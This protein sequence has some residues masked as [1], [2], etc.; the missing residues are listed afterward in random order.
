MPDASLPLAKP[1]LEETSNLEL[2]QRACCCSKKLILLCLL[3]GLALSTVMQ[4]VHVGD[5]QEQA[6]TLA[7]EYIHLAG[8]QQQLL[9][10]RQAWQHMPSWQC[11]HSGRG[12][13]V[14]IGS[15]SPRV[16]QVAQVSGRPR[17]CQ[18]SSLPYESGELSEF[19]TTNAG[20]KMPRLIYTTVSQQESTEDHVQRAVHAGFKGLQTAGQPKQYYE[21]GVGAALKSLFASGISRES[22]FIQTSF[23]PDYAA[24]L[25]PDE[26]IEDQ[27]K[28]SIKDS[29]SNLGL[30]YVDSLLLDLPYENHKQTME[31]WRTMEAAVRAGLVRQLGMSNVETQMQLRVILR[32]AELKPAVVQVSRFNESKR[33]MQAMCAKSGIHIQSFKSLDSDTSLFETMQGFATKYSVTPSA[34]F[35]RFLMG[36]GIVPLTATFSDE[37]MR[38]D[39]SAYR[40]PLTS[41]D[42]VK[43]YEL[44]Q[45][46]NAL[47][48][49]P[50]EVS[51]ANSLGAS[52]QITNLTG[53]G[54]FLSTERC[55]GDRLIVIKFY[56]KWC[57]TCKAM[58]KQ[59]AQLAL[60]FPE[61]RFFEMDYDANR[62]L[63]R[64]LGISILPYVEMYR[65]ADGKLEGFSCGPSKMRMLKNK[66]ETYDQYQTRPD[67]IMRAKV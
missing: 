32:D 55:A 13:S 20:V 29:L 15:S 21:P 17:A 1:L 59:F 63:C 60:Q 66:L 42:A 62:D 16:A 31:A 22:L 47:D 28:L 50:E 44:L 45:Q 14:M 61:A 7:R 4:S 37:R 10:L 53:L 54:E 56:A 46:Q 5:I 8:P 36:V 9:H 18:A 48:P 35:F 34:L 30:N 11:M 51:Y 40:V 25:N 41:D 26:S 58:G 57:R 67:Q 6:I 23:N 33:E 27:V 19:V 38:K 65:G 52:G 43:M 39:I 64:S 49:D 3:V 12:T 24:E 2:P